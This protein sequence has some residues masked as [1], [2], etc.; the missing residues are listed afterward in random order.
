MPMPTDT[1]NLAR[2]LEAQAECYDRVLAELHAG[3]KQS[4]WMWFV[5]P[6]LAG[7]GHSATARY[8]AL[9]GA[10][11]AAAYLD[12]DVLGKRLQTCCDALLQLKEVRAI[13]IFG[14]VDAIKLRSCV[15]LFDSLEPGQTF[16][17]VVE[18]YYGGTRD[19][20]TLALLDAPATA[21]PQSSPRTER[22]PGS[23]TDS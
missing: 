10:R 13:D 22:Q 1:Y 17:R 8:F 20:A 9:S 19:P 16:A 12:H 2:F 4:H 21:L 5:F 7:L 23:L 15:T 18:R 14:A 3:R 11:E 6:Q